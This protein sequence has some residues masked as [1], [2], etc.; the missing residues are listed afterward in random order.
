MLQVYGRQVRGVW[1][2]LGRGCLHLQV[3]SLKGQLGKR[4][5]HSAGWGA[6]LLLAV[7]RGPDMAGDGAIASRT[8]RILSAALK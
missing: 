1:V 4:G 5:Q 8:V 6:D 7:R 2:Q 3:L